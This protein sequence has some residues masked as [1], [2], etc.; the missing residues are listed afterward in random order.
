MLRIEIA[1]L[2]DDDFDVSLTGFDA[3]ALAELMAGD[4][5]DGEGHAQCA[6]SLPTMEKR[7]LSTSQFSPE[8]TLPT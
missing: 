6:P 7:L 8:S 5:P 4:E 2:Q 1:S 3:D